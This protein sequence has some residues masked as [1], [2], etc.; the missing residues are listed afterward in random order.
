VHLHRVRNAQRGRRNAPETRLC[1]GAHRPYSGG[2]PRRNAAEV[3]RESEA[4]DQSRSTTNGQAIPRPTNVRGG[5]E[6]T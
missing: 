1:H 6:I 2:R 3:D 5:L 4:G